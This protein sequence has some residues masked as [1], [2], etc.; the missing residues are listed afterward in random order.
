[1]MAIDILKTKTLYT[2]ETKTH[3][4]PKAKMHYRLKTKTHYTL[5]AK[6]YCIP[7]TKIQDTSY[8]NNLNLDV[9]RERSAPD[10]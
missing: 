6:T 3:Y 1:M 10:I 7:Q 2:P 5:D 4:I 8:S 9:A